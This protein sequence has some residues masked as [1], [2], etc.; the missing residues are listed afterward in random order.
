MSDVTAKRHNVDEAAPTMASMKSRLGLLMAALFLG[1]CGASVPNPPGLVEDTDAGVA[2]IVATAD[3]WTW[4]DFPDSHCGGGSATGIGWN[5]HP[6]STTLVLYLEGG[7][8]CTDE[9][10]CWI[11]PEAMY[12]GGYGQS[13][14]TQNID[15]DANPKATDGTA[16]VLDRHRADNP[17]ADANL[18]YVPYCTGD[19]HGGTTTQ[20]LSAGL[21]PTYFYGAK[22]LAL[23][24]DA[25]KASFPELTRVWLAGAS[26]GGYGTVLAHEQVQSALGI[27]VDSIDDSGPFIPLPASNSS[28]LSLKGVPQVWGLQIPADCTSCDTAFGYFQ[29]VRQKHPDTRY[30]YVGFEYDSVIPLYGQLSADDYHADLQ[31]YVAGF[32][33]NARHFLVHND[34]AGASHVVWDTMLSLDP[35]SAE[36]MSF[37]A[38]MS[39]WLTQ[40]K[41]DDAAWSDVDFQP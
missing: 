18:V 1:A 27:R 10:S 38:Q 35:K 32:D 17:F 5:P 36:A 6:G 30:G 2:P 13:D 31:T 24:L 4:V 41:T 8:A 34:A 7:G 33:A 3:Q 25:I 22:N 9:F 40:L 39:T 14:F 20:V 23:Y 21:A 26:A 29:Y 19:L 28:L 11:L 12:M 15:I 16:I 37:N